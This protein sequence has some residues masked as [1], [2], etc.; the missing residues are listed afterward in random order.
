VNTPSSQSRLRAADA[1]WFK[2]K[3][4]PL[5][6]TQGLNA[7]ASEVRG[8]LTTEPMALSK[9]PLEGKQVSSPVST[10]GGG[11]LFQARTQALYLANMLTGL[12][13]APG[14]AGGRVLSVRFEARYT[15]AHTD[16]IYCEVEGASAEG[17]RCFVQCKRKFD[18]TE[19]DSTFTDAFQAAWRDWLQQGPF[20]RSRDTLSIASTAPASPSLEAAREV[21]QLARASDDLADFQRKLGAAG[22]KA[23]RVLEAW[24]VLCELS[25]PMLGTAYSEDEVLA[26]TKRLRLDVHD[27]GSDD[28]QEMVLLAGLLGAWCSQP[29]KGELFR[30]GLTDYCLEMGQRPGTA[31][32]ASWRTSASAALQEAFDAG[33][34]GASGATAAWGKLI[35]RAQHQLG[36]VGAALPN[37]VHL[38][39][40]ALQEELLT[41]ATEH[42]LVVVT[43]DAGV[44]KSGAV[45]TAARALA[46][47]NPLIFFR[48]D[49]LDSPSLDASLVATGITSGV[50][51]L[52][53]AFQ[54]HDRVV[55]VID[56]LEK[57]LEFAKRGALEELLGLA[58]KHK[59]V[60]VVVTARSYALAPLLAN[61]LHT[62]SVGIVEVH[63][64]SE[65]E[66]ASVLAGSEFT[67]AEQQ[68]EQLRK[69]AIAR[70]KSAGTL[71]SLT[72]GELRK[73]L[74]E[75]AVAPSTSRAG[76]A[77]RRRA[78]FDE[79]CFTRTERLTQFVDPPSDAEAVESLKRDGILVADSVG[80]VA[81]GHDVLEDWSLYFRIERE[82]ARAEQDWAALFEALGTHSG[83]RRAFRSWT[84]DQA[85]LGNEDALRLL[86]HCVTSTDAPALWRDEAL[87]GLLRSDA[88]ERLLSR[89]EPELTRNDFALLHRVIHLLRVAC[90]GPAESQAASFDES[91][92]AKEA[93]IRAAMTTPVGDSW[94]HVVSLVDK[95][96]S[97]LE[98]GA[99]HKVAALLE[100]AVKGCTWY[101]ET[102]LSK[103]VHNIAAHYVDNFDDA[104]SHDDR[105]L[106]KRFFSLFIGGVANDPPRVQAYLNSLIGRVRAARG[107]RR[108]LK[109]EE[110]LGYLLG[111][112]NSIA[113]S[114]FLPSTVWA[115][116]VAM[117][118]RAGTHEDEGIR[119]SDWSRGSSFGIRD[120]GASPFFPASCMSGP[121]RH[122]LNY[123]PKTALRFIVSLANDAAAHFRTSAT[124]SVVVIP[125]Q[126]SPNGKEHLHSE[127]FWLYYRGL[128]V[129]DDLL[130]SA[131]MALEER[132]LFD[133]ESD[134]S[135]ASEHL[136][137]LLDNGTSTFTT[138]VAA[139]VLT[140]H[141]R[142]FAEQFLRLARCPEF[143]LADHRRLN[144]E[145]MP[146]AILGG[147]DGLDAF[148]QRE[149]HE[150][151]NLPHRKRDLEFLA[152]QLQVEGVCRTEI[153]A[154]L[155]EHIRELAA[156][157]ESERDD[158]WRVALKRMD[159]RGLKFGAPVGEG[160]RA[161]EIAELDEDLAEKSKLAE[162][163]VAHANRRAGLHLWAASATGRRKKDAEPLFSSANEVLEALRQVHEQEE[164]H[165]AEI[166][167]GFDQ[168]VAAG[169]VLEMFQ[170][171]ASC[172][173]WAAATLSGPRL[174]QLRAG[175]D[176]WGAIAC[177]VVRLLVVRASESR[178]EGAVAELA[179]H[180]DA[181]VRSAFAEA[182][183]A[184]RR[185][186]TDPVVITLASALAR[187]A[188]LTGMATA[189]PCPRGERAYQ[190]ARR[191]A[192]C[193]LRRTFE[194][195]APPTPEMAKLPARAGDWVIA[196]RAAQ[197]LSDWDWRRNT[198]D[199]LVELAAAAENSRSEDRE[200]DFTSRKKVG[201][202]FASE[203]LRTDTGG[204][205]ALSRLKG[206]IPTAPEF[207]DEVLQDV[208]LA[209]DAREHKDAR[210]FWAVWDEASSIVFAQRSLRGA[211]SSRFE[212]VLRQLLL[213]G[214]PWRQGVYHLA[215][216][217]ER[218]MYVA[219]CL[220]QVGDTRAGL[221]GCLDLL[222]SVARQSSIPS[223]LPALR[224][225]VVKQGAEAF[226]PRNNQWN[227]ELVCRL[228]VHQHR[229]ELMRNKAL[230]EAVLDIL[231]ALVDAGSSI[232]FQLRDYLATASSKA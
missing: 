117:H 124:N 12:P 225:A 36:L 121:F 66:L 53:A 151:N 27:V 80:R 163:R 40:L 178:I 220:R 154:A 145:H 228:A 37:G 214:V 75:E 88:A 120:H 211:H 202:L 21:C 207:C 104:W 109:A 148:R 210:R 93:H 219:E 26:F 57:A 173:E 195:N 156:Q 203:L 54:V 2:L 113:P 176:V 72:A 10:G 69:L 115:A 129:S 133:A 63:P 158:T 200:L 187:Y 134:P 73:F 51:V 1:R 161:L 204:A 167:S 232:G 229:E 14:V 61:F 78:V 180:R 23:K 230:R 106:H 86:A 94:A 58:A 48:A 46:A 34:A 169:L 132:L 179:F 172:D 201:K 102:A 62:S 208:L 123:H 74:W 71:P 111:F 30:A 231:T 205:K 9:N 146:L 217:D 130:A 198:L 155:D 55:L 81:P 82:V 4:P 79:T 84:A 43:G 16:D 42:P 89:F 177:A 162:T 143:F 209:V 191:L 144:G 137:W 22:L 189:R 152:L 114:A 52:D 166:Y 33:I 76:L 91:E 160:R 136:I 190:A 67:P 183:N 17:W 171:D 188:E 90:K 193:A 196:L 100:D 11:A 153:F 141:P 218:P 159:L 87:I 119:H 8:R 35:A 184:S 135:K 186:L 181:E 175:R 70:R 92:L 13:T 41:R 212:R 147:H 44:G 150:S 170:Q 59:S 77:Q 149:R 107:R 60:Q 19:S 101:S 56:S 215:I 29:E 32:A 31:T 38:D 194:G 224:D 131:L 116:L 96:K 223:A 206:L 99:W 168:E 6:A 197:G 50:L 95:H 85:D 65:E 157:A 7:F 49:E 185:E 110:R 28:T 142:L 25:K 165:E 138:A 221:Q 222:T 112:A 18:V 5:P 105:T 139:S 98:A 108:D 192:Q 118:I 128:V 216:L 140:A 45:V 174:A 125:P 164:E 83:L 226:T 199:S 24:R 68:N 15:G 182:V 126:K 3:L 213:V 39:R 47:G 20:R 122:L 97:S 127:V 227:A 64:L 103:A